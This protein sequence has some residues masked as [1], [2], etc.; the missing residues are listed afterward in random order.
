MNTDQIQIRLTVS[1]RLYEFLQGKSLRLG[2]A[3]TQ[4]VKHLIVKEAETENYPVF[5]ASL[6]TEEKYAQAQ[7]KLDKFIKVD[8]VNK[9]LNSL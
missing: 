6:K 1:D 9:Y 2:V 3:V 7:K 4:V 5:P 8:D